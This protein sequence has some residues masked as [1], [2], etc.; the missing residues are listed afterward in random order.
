MDCITEVPHG[1]QYYCSTL[2][3]SHATRVRHHSSLGAQIKESLRLTPLRQDNRYASFNNHAPWKL[4]SLLFRTRGELTHGADNGPTT[5]ATP[6]CSGLATL[7]KEFTP[8]VGD[9]EGTREGPSG[10][11]QQR[12]LRRGDGPSNGA[13]RVRSRK[14]KFSQTEV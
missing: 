10:P 8:D 4:P 14:R 6:V 7:E 12:Y 3:K 2:G 13:N 5:T 9:L 11:L 1:V